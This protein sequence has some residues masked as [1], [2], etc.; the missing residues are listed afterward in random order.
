MTNRDLSV[1]HYGPL[2]SFNVF[3]SSDGWWAA[4]L[5]CIFE[6]K[7]W[8]LEF[9]HPFGDSAVRW[10]KV[11]VNILQLLANF[12]GIQLFLGENT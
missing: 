3:I 12:D 2:Y 8:I 11:L 4:H 5:R 6:G 1:T 7:F 10:S 9:S